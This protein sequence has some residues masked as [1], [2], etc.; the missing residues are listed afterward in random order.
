MSGRGA[1]R[2]LG[3]RRT[4]IVATLGPAS[5]TPAMVERLLAAGMD[6]AR[7]NFSHGTRAEHGRQ[8]EV[9]REAARKLGRTVAVLQDLQGPKVRVGRVEGGGVHLAAGTEVELV[10][11]DGAPGTSA[12]LGVSLRSLGSQLAPGTAVLIDDGRLR[13]RVTSVRGEAVRCVVEVGGVVRD[14]KGVNV[15]GATLDVPCLTEKDLDDL[16]FG[17]ECGVDLVALSFVRSAAD[18]RV[19]REH[20][21]RLGGP[22]RVVAKIEKHEALDRIEEIVEEADAVMVARGDLGVEIPPEEVPRWQKAIIRAAVT[23]ARAVITATQM[24][25]SMTSAPTPTRAE[26]SDVANAVYDGTTA[27]MLS[28]ETAVGAFPVES[29]ATMARI[30]ET[31]EGDLFGPGALGGAHGGRDSG[32]PG[33]ASP[34]LNRHLPTASVCGDVETAVPTSEAISRA[35]CSLAED[36][37]AAAILTPTRSGA[38]A[39]QVSRW[40]PRVPIVATTPSAE[41]AAQLCLEWGVVPLLVSEAPDTDG[42]V[43]LAVQ[44]ARESGLLRRGDLAV[45]TCGSLV[46]VPGSTDVIKVERA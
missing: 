32:V 31:V 35:A 1:P 25:E 36:L 39:R 24:L 9:V 37:R 30:V 11:D 15:P 19:L 43:D 38:T 16:A 6:V 5:E 12:R 28:G 2:E 33:L 20:L 14:H 40:R 7:V 22:A 10:P 18:V 4:R 29:V 45:V 21:G 42:T 26:A 41:V 44:T 23:R 34:G 8:I 3:R 17:V 46:N 13:L 27:V